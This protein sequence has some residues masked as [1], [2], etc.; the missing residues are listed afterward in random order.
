MNH[1]DWS[2]RITRH[3]QPDGSVTVPPRIAAWLESQAGLTA[4]RRINLRTTD[5]EAYVALAALH[6]AAL[7]SDSGTEQSAGQRNTA[8]SEM[9]LS[10]SEAAKAMNVTDRCVRKWCATGRL[11]AQLVGG[12]WLINPNSIALHHIT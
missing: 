4:D 3:I 2:D 7:S 5:P 12:R 1:D 11:R 10:T 8:R 9:W 6:L